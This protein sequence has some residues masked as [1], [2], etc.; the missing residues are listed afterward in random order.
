MPLFTVMLEYAGGTY[1]AQGEASNT[2]NAVSRWARGLPTE[3]ALA[4]NDSAEDFIAALA[5][6]PQ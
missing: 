3:V 5:T 6:S 4:T 2:K 1:L